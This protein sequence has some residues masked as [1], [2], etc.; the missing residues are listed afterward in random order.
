MAKII[1]IPQKYWNISPQKS[2]RA[3]HNLKTGQF[4]GRIV[5]SG[6]NA[7]MTRTRYLKHNTDLNHDGK[8]SSNEAGGTLIGRYT[9]VKGNARARGYRR[10]I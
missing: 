6:K 5:T 10:R 1:Q 2:T 8:I 9:T 4:T 7:D 3:T